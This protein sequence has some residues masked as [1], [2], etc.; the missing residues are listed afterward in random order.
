MLANTGP[1]GTTYPDFTPFDV[2]KIRCH[3]G[4]YILQGS[5]PSP[6]IEYKFNCQCDNPAESNDYVWQAT[7]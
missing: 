3:V 2:D 5:L 6:R 7:A 4:I 1:G